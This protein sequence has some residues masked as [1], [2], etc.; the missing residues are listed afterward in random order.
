MR[1]KSAKDGEGWGARPPPFNIS[2]IIYKFEVYGPAERADTLP[3]FLLYPYMYSVV[4]T[5]K[6]QP[7][8]L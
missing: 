8:N 7:I 5:T 1:V 6:E 4:Y 3:L 2:T